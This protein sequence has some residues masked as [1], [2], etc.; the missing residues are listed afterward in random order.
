M[1][2]RGQL[3]MVLQDLMAYPCRAKW[4]KLYISI[5]Y[6]TSDISYGNGVESFSL[7][8]EKI[9]SILRCIFHDFSDFEILC[10]KCHKGDAVTV[11]GLAAPVMTAPI[12]I[13]STENI[14]TNA[15]ENK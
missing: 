2:L 7:Q 13:A 11:T 5:D 15:S 4:R 3:R 12:M 1:Q 14:T 10:I 8:L 6:T 9:I